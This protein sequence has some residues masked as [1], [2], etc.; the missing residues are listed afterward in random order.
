[1]YEAP[2]ANLL[3]WFKSPFN[4]F[5][6][7]SSPLIFLLFLTCAE[8]ILGAGSAVSR[9]AT[10]FSVCGVITFQTLRSAGVVLQQVLLLAAETVRG[11]PLT[12]RT[13]GGARL[14]YST[15]RKPSE[16]FKYQCEVL[17]TYNNAA[18]FCPGTKWKQMLHLWHA[19][20]HQ[21]LSK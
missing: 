2:L 21:P 3:Y 20:T 8:A 1:M 9:A 11:F 7:K 16:K 18:A 17:L 5:L 13:L 4:T 14:T 12:G 6:D 15:F 10:A 19:S